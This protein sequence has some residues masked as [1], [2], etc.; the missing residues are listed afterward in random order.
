MKIRISSRKSDLARIQTYQVAEALRAVHPGIEI[1]FQFSQSLGDK[2]LEDPLWQMPEKGVFTR[3]L[4]DEL[5]ENR[6]DLVVHSWKDLPI[7]GFQTTEVYATLAREDMRDLLL[8]K[9][10]SFEKYKKKKHAPLKILS[11][12]PR[13]SH[14]LSRYLSTSLPFLEPGIS[15]LPIRGNVGTRIKKFLESDADGMILAAAAVDR[16]LNPPLGIE[17]SLE[18]S[19]S[20]LKT[21]LESLLWSF[22]PLRENPTAAAQGA[23]AIELRKDRDDL[24]KLLDSINNR[25]VFQD[26]SEER[27]MLAN[28]GGGCHQ[29]LGISIIRRPFGRVLSVR[30]ESPNGDPIERWEILETKTVSKKRSL[31]SADLWPRNPSEARFFERETMRVE[32]PEGFAAFFVSRSESWPTSWTSNPMAEIIW[33]SGAKSWKKLA[34]QGLWVHGSSE[35]L[36]EERPRSLFKKPIDRSLKLTHEESAATSPESLATYRLVALEKEDLPAF[37][38]Y[39]AYYWMSASAFLR[40]LELDPVLWKAEHACGPGN[41]YKRLSPLFQAKGLHLELC[42]DHEH[43]MKSLLGD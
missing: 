29:K 32:K 36:G 14:N 2:N 19:A 4:Q 34:S 23:L 3:D 16:L 39:R 38:S 15:F 18:T 12:S 27:K 5:I 21:T 1:S 17:K 28:F 8:F 40:A 22:L 25:D 37:Q 11:S 24:K 6:T 42:L 9:N 33:V 26:V 41:T 20:H 13:R 7:E 30:G 35:S 43:W 31:K 10:E